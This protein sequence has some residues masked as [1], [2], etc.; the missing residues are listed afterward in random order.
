MLIFIFLI[1][2]FKFQTEKNISERTWQE[3]YNSF[4]EDRTLFT[5]FLTPR[6]TQELCYPLDDWLDWL[7]PANHRTDYI[8]RRLIRELNV[9]WIRAYFCYPRFVSYVDKTSMF[10]RTFGKCF[11]YRGT[12]IW[13]HYGRWTELRV[14][15]LYCTF[16]LYLIWWN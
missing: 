13:K 15:S 10:L 1:E 9:W 6:L 16:R 7:I 11:A 4:W 8:I 14:S 2:I 3:S 12:L 5:K